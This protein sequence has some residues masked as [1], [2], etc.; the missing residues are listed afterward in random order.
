LKN[1]ERAGVRLRV[2]KKK[3]KN[4]ERVTKEGKKKRCTFAGWEGN[5]PAEEGAE[6]GAK[7]KDFGGRGVGNAELSGGAGRK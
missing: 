4:S 2:G 5:V 3:K 7:E 1:H 6:R